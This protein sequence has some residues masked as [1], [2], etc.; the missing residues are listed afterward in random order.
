MVSEGVLKLLDT[1]AFASRVVN[2]ATVEF[3]VSSGIWTFDEEVAGSGALIK[4]GDGTLV[5]GGFQDH[6]PG[7]IFEILGGT[8]EMNTD[9]SGTGLT[10]DADL[11]ILVDDAELRF[12]CN[13]HLDTLE[14]GE[15]GLVRLTGAS[16]VVVKHL[17]MDGVDLGATTLTPEPATLALLAAGGLGLALRRRRAQAA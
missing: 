4:S 1:T 13:Q 17:I 3:E 5:F 8:V 16:V 7:A 11:S 6:E 12:G 10:E 2:Y 15:D 14:I 9:A